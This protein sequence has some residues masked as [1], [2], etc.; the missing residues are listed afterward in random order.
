MGSDLDAGSGQHFPHERSALADDVAHQGLRHS[1]L[2]TRQK[3][4]QENGSGD[5]ADPS[6]TVCVA[7]AK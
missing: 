6:T 3:N 1:D 5:A 7:I 2:D 4:T